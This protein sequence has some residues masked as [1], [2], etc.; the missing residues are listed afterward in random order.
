VNV[1]PVKSTALGHPDEVRLEASGAAGNRDFYFV[2]ED[3]RLQ[4]GSKF[5][6]YVQIVSNHDAET[7]QLTLRF[8]DGTT[9]EGAATALGP[10]ITTNFYG[11]LVPAHVLD[12]PWSA[13]ISAFVGR[14]IRLARVD[15]AGDGSDIRPVTLVSLASVDELSRR[16]GANGRVDPGRFRMLFELDGCAPHEEDSWNG[17]RLAIGQAVVRIGDPVPRCVVTTQDPKTGVRDFPT[18]S[19]I[20]QY[21]GVVNGELNF[22]V[23]GDVETPGIVRVG[24]EA[25][26]VDHARA[27]AGRDAG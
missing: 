18:L 10:A 4:G 3:G 19:V 11:R 7:D 14:T 2:D 9:V 17:R 8:P 20:K 27:I 26:L 22:G 16:G 21:R 15:R 6:P 1:T 5:G 23:Y 25:R 12:G 13:A 24:D